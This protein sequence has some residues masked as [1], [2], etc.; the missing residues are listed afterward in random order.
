MKQIAFIVGC[1]RS[2][3]STLSDTLERHPS[4]EMIKPK[5]PETRFF[6]K[7][8]SKN[9]AH[10]FFSY[11]SEKNKENLII[12]KSTSYIENEKA[13]RQIKHTFE[14][15][16]IIV[17]FRDPVVRAFSNYLFTKKNLGDNRSFIK[18]FYDE[19]EK[20]DGVS[21]NPYDYRQRGLYINYLKLL[22]SIFKR[23]QL[24]FLTFEDMLKN[25]E[26]FFSLLFRRLNLANTK[27]N[28]IKKINSSISRKL[29]KNDYLEIYKFYEQS[30]ESLSKYNISTNL[31]NYNFYNEIN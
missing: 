12:E 24:I 9:E 31:W 15:C 22:E 25:H 6:F 23:E 3:S 13:L 5:V 20:P 4:I 27:I 1:Q 26:K 14:N 19:K 10:N 16:I 30:Y 7:E 18:A 21:V 28:E 8:R 2:G 11:N 17:I 29:S